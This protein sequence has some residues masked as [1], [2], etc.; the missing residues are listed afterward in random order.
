MLRS[1]MMRAPVEL[2]PADAN[3]PHAVMGALVSHRFR[4]ERFWVASLA[5]L[6]EA[7]DSDQIAPVRAFLEEETSLD[8][9]SRVLEEIHD[10]G[11][12]D[13]MIETRHYMFHR[14]R[15]EYW[16]AGRTGP[17]GQLNLNV[18]LHDA[19]GSVLLAGIDAFDRTR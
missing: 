7:W 18:R 9:L 5:V 15:R 2:E 16:N 13:R 4:L 11:S 17:I 10:S 14:D 8:E 19:F 1:L 12:Y 3:D 6:V